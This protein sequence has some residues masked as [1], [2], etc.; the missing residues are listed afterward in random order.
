MCNLYRT[1]NIYITTRHAEN[2]TK[3]QRLHQDAVFDPL[4]S[5]EHLCSNMLHVRM[6][7]ACFMVHTDSASATKSN[8]EHVCVFLLV[9]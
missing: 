5:R 2:T 6:G 3:L 9:S 4:Y 8:C 1:E 7:Q